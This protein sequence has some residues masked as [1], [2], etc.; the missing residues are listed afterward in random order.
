M[1]ALKESRRILKRIQVN[2]MKVLISEKVYG[3]TMKQMEINML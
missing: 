1:K 3:K 2:V